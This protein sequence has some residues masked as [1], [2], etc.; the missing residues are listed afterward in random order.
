VV[1]SLATRVQVFWVQ[2]R[3]RFTGQR[4]AVATEYVLLVSLIAVAIVAAA[5]TFGVVLSNKYSEACSVFNGT[6]CP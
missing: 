4:G 3:D 2:L 6:T 1:L 5:T